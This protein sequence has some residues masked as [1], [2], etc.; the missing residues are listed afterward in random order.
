MTE[1]A[2][3]EGDP[4]TGYRPIGQILLLVGAVVT[5]MLAFVPLAIALDPQTA[6][7]IRLKL[8]GPAGHA[9]GELTVA[10]ISPRGRA[11]A[12][13]R[14]GGSGAWV[15]SNAWARALR[16]S[17]PTKTLDAITSVELQL[18]E[19]L[20][21]IPASRLRREAIESGPVPR[22]PALQLDTSVLGEGAPLPAGAR[23]FINWP[24]MGQRL[25]QLALWPAMLALALLLAATLSAAAWRSE[26]LGPICR[27]ALAPGPAESEPVGS[28]EPD[29]E[30]RA[31]FLG[32]LTFLVLALAALEW[33]DACYFTRDDNLVA[34]LPAM[35]YGCRSLAAG[36]FPAWTP[37]FLLG[38]PLAEMAFPALFYPPTLL[39]WWMATQVLGNEHLTLE[40]F[41]WAHLLAAYLMT[42]RLLRIVGARPSLACP[43]TLSFVLSGFF[44]VS[45][46]SWHAFLASAAWTPLMVRAAV[47]LARQG[48]SWRWATW[49]G[50]AIGL[51]F[52]AGHSQ[53]WLNAVSALWCSA[54]LLALS[55]AMPLGR[56]LW[57]IPPCILGLGLAA[58]VMISEVS[59]VADAARIGGLGGGIAR[60]L[61][62][63]L[64]PYPLA[65]A[66]HPNDLVGKHGPEMTQFYYSGTVFFA[67]GVATCLLLVGLLLAR[68]GAVATA[69]AN[70]W[71][72]NGAAFLLLS[73]GRPGF[74]W[75]S[76]GLLPLLNKFRDPYR[77][78]PLA[79][80]FLV[81]SGA[82]TL[83]R[84]LPRGS[85]AAGAERAIAACV[86]MLL[87]HHV[88]M[89]PPPHHDYGFRPYPAMADL[90][91]ET[92]G[93]DA[94]CL[95]LIPRLG[96]APDYARALSHNL[97]AVYGAHSMTGYKSIVAV[98]PENVR[99][100]SRF[101]KDSLEALKRYGVRWVVEHRLLALP[102]VDP[103]SLEGFRG[104]GP[105]A[106][107]ALAWQVN[108][109][110]E[111]V[112]G[113]EAD[114]DRALMRRVR[115]E[116]RRVTRLPG[117]TVWE[118]GGADPIAFPRGRAGQALPCVQGP[119]GVSV[120]VSALTSGAAV[121]VNVL[122][123]RW[124]RAAADGRAIQVDSDDWD[125]VVAQCPPGAKQLQV[126]Y[127][128]P[129][130]RWFAVTACLVLLGLATTFA[131]IGFRGA[132]RAPV[133]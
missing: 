36:Q 68:R 88:S 111:S 84:L 15:A 67:V 112:L 73:L 76:I 62:A 28:G 79:T 105:I 9:L 118:M 132:A 93:T 58:P 20:W 125:R 5:C 38:S 74:I 3:R 123:R 18:G 11:C 131:M 10:R 24:E 110:E 29:R 129:W 72:V 65:Y 106:R 87:A 75:L 43:A 113:A 124:M 121:V 89:V 39:C 7:P 90:L 8:V 119:A 26:R 13:E 70:P 115:A 61:T 126:L 40:V 80:L 30:G 109:T 96:S 107:A 120:D 34:A 27:R 32:G 64:L 78:L 98:S 95:P 23:V 55:G 44:L 35:L 114:R 97:P 108:E 16:I 50:M 133:A 19:R 116:A 48:P 81:I 12:L 47:L 103:P 49:L 127:C 66:R 52:H 1:P 92:I 101:E 46:R 21:N 104:P 53:P 4:Q 56:M 17:A 45:G 2:A 51:S 60:G 82:L 77:Y 54:G 102:P 128:P 69:A 6:L 57:L 117:V 99:A 85:K 22:H 33:F 130:G 122:N 37:S 94:R 86:A 91:P 25:R 100:A 42:F 41:S 14:D 83:E 63:L 31:W 71:A 59:L